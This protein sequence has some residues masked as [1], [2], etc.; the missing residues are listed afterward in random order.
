MKKIITILL[1]TISACSYSQPTEWVLHN[2]SLFIK[3]GSDSVY[4]SQYMFFD[5][6]TQLKA[7]IVSAQTALNLKANLASPTFTGTVAGITAAMVGLPNVTNESKATMFSSPTFTGTATLPASTSLTTP[8]IGAATG[9]S[10]AATGAITSS[11][12]GI[13]YT[14][15]NG[16]T[17]TQI[18]SKST[19]VTL[20]K[21]AGDI[22]MIN[23]A[24][25]AATIVSFTL[26][27]STIAAT[28][29]IHVQH[30]AT[31]T[32]GAYTITGRSASGSAVISVRNNTAGSL[33]E[34]IVIK[35][36]IVK[37]VTN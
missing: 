18:T 3:R 28:D 29:I 33:S 17:V 14:S 7:S 22:T 8:V 4:Y 11:G 24:L 12:G 19:G 27:N 32:F 35:F 16:G 21:L 36:L 5:F 13:G 31:G 20:N 25:A 1:L 9:T 6:I 26:T 15:G 30:N 10:L 23:S 2:D 34:A 37:S